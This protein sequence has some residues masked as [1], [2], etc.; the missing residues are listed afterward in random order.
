MNRRCGLTAR[1]PQLRCGRTVRS[2]N[3]DGGTV[4]PVPMGEVA[5]VKSH[6]SLQ[7]RFAV[8]PILTIARTEAITGF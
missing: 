1:Y 4:P 3:S 2:Q 6:T 5:P 8:M 7:Q